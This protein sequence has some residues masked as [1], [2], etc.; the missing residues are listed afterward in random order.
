MGRIIVFNVSHCKTRLLLQ[1]KKY[2][3]RPLNYQVTLNAVNNAR[4]ARAVLPSDYRQKISRVN[5]GGIQTYTFLVTIR[6]S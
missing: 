3:T 6:V 1:G 5:E 2:I 4:I